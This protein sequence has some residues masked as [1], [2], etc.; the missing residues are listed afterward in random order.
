MAGRISFRIKQGSANHIRLKH[1]EPP[2]A[3]IMTPLSGD[4][5]D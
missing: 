4:I 2:F 1:I 3:N 5:L